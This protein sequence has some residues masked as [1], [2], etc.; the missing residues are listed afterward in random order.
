MEFTTLMPI[1][2]SNE[3]VIYRPDSDVEL[4]YVLIKKPYFSD[5][6]LLKIFGHDRTQ[7]EQ[8]QNWL[9]I[10]TLLKKSNICQSDLCTGI[11][12]ML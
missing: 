5:F 7:I 6:A 3:I 8:T 1:G 4:E 12:P 2:N 11:I 10:Q 9:R